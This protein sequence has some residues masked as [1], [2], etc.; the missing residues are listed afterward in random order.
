MECLFKF[1][2]RFNNIDEA[3][4]RCVEIINNDP[5]LFLIGDKSYIYNIN[6]NISE[7]KNTESYDLIKQ[8][9]LINNII[10]KTLVS[11]ILLS[12]PENIEV[13][14]INCNPSVLNEIVES[15]ER[16]IDYLDTKIYKVDFV[17]KEYNG[18]SLTG[19]PQFVINIDEEK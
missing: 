8:I 17:E 3:K 4:L 15:M 2:G 6:G 12:N 14:F 18:I 16:Y 7:V 10:L 13:K 5:L 11:S 1:I 9:D 19:V